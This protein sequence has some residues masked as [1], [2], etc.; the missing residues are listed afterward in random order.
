MIIS[1]IRIL[2]DQHAPD[3]TY[4]NLYIYDPSNA[5]SLSPNAVPY[6]F[7]DELRIDQNTPIPKYDVPF[8]EGGTICPIG[9]TETGFTIEIPT[10]GDFPARPLYLILTT[11]TGYRYAFIDSYTRTASS[12]IRCV[13]RF[14]QWTEHFAELYASAEWS[15]ARS[16]QRRYINRFEPTRTKLYNGLSDP[17]AEGM[18]QGTEK[19]NPLTVY[20][21]RKSPTAD[22][23]GH[24][25]IPIWLYWRL[26]T[27]EYYYK[28]S[29]SGDWT[30]PF[31]LYGVDVP[32]FNVPT[33]ATCLGI[34]DYDPTTELSSFRPTWKVLKSD[35][36][37][38]TS[39]AGPP[40]SESETTAL[41]YALDTIHKG[42]PYIA[43]AYITTIPPFPVSLVFDSVNG[44]PTVR[45][46]QIKIESP[47]DT[48]RTP[49]DGWYYKIGQTSDDVPASLEVNPGTFIDFPISTFYSFPTG[50]RQSYTVT[51][52]T[53]STTYDPMSEPKI[54]ESPYERTILSIY[55]AEID[56]SP[57]PANPNITLKVTVGAHGDLVLYSGS[58][59][60]YRASGV[61]SQCGVDTS[62]S[63]LVSWLVSNYQ[64]YQNS[65]LWKTINTAVGAGTSIMTG[66]V[67]GNVG[68]VLGGGIKAITGYGETLTGER[69]RYADL[70]AS[71]NATTLASDNAF[72]NFPFID[73]PRIKKRTIPD[74]IKSRITAFWH[75]YGYPD[76]RV[77]TIADGL[78]RMDFH[79][80]QASLVRAPAGL[81][82]GEYTAIESALRS[83]VWLWM[84][85]HWYAVPPIPSPPGFVSHWLTT[86]RFAPLLSLDNPEI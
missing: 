13:A 3:P 8:P 12:K 83:G 17:A 58:T 2:Y 85:R 70:A 31:A 30:G 28:T 47:Y 45:R 80:L 62:T 50:S 49:G 51:S 20:G 41:V 16:H 40:G 26:S 65:K 67:T 75:I 24:I 69:A 74:A 37:V 21:A 54:E 19:V 57:T 84:T 72:D 15:F 18:V 38:L 66:M 43:Q 79:Y 68:A 39:P 60:I 82:P 25:V 55:G 35:N 61:C 56:V 78:N 73:L 32:K 23:S 6:A 71:P 4:K 11:E 22:A 34:I 10:D 29:Y 5:G 27:Q 76:N 33:L 36:T 52:N 77:G 64:T 48:V 44:L 42:H 59:E 1:A 9:E 53:E 7:F 46:P 14:D 63:S 81:Y 86:P